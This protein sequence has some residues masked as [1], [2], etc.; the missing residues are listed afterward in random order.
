VISYSVARRNREFG[1][2]VALGAQVGDIIGLVLK[3]GAVLA[4]AGIGLGLLG[5]AWLTRF[6]TTSGH[7]G[8]LPNE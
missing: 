4:A 5:G 7:P 2:R 6:L 1:V 3:H 8:A